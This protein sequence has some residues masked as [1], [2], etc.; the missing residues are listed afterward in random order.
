MK[1]TIMCLEKGFDPIPIV[2][3][4][5]Y[6]GINAN[7]FTLAPNLVIAFENGKAQLMRNE[8]DTSMSMFIMK[9]VYIK[10]F[11]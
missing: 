1:V 5:W 11:F 8:S 2:G 9:S 10:I 6:N 3:L 4:D 7:M